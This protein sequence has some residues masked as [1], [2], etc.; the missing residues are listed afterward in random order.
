MNTV[1]ILCNE[2]GGWLPFEQKEGGK[3]YFTHFSHSARKPDTVIGQVQ[4]DSRSPFF[5]SFLSYFI[6]DASYS[7][8]KLLGF[9]FCLI[10]ISL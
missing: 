6:R 8:E 2:T 9:Y 3:S 10:L 5:F 1:L 4:Q 7:F